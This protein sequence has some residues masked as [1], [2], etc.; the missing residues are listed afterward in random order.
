VYKVVLA[1]LEQ[2]YVQSP[3]AATEVRDLEI[4]QT[5]SR[6]FSPAKLTSVL[7]SVA[8]RFHTTYIVL[9]AL[10]ECSGL[11]TSDLDS[12]LRSLVLSEC[13]LFVTSRPSHGLATFKSNH[14]PPIAIQTSPEDMELVVRAKFQTVFERGIRIQEA[15]QEQI[16]QAL[17][18]LGMQH[19]MFVGTSSRRRSN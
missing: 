16:A 2:L 11:H 17:T 4:Q 18:E 14:S 19:G 10:D 1:L 9:D 12:V 8:A 15:Q 6:D 13:Y 5:Q 7:M 3:T